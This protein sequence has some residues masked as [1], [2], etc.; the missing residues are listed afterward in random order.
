VV[1]P[2]VEIEAGLRNVVTAIA[3]TLRPGAMLGC[4]VLRATLLPGAMFLPAAALL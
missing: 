4:P 2:E 3:S 1:A